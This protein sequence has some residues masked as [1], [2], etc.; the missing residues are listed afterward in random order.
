MVGPPKVVNLQVHI[1]FF[2]EHNRWTVFD[3][4]HNRTPDV[5]GRLPFD[6]A[7]LL[8]QISQFWW[9]QISHPGQLFF[10]ALQR[11]NLHLWLSIT[12][13]NTR[14]SPNL[15]LGRSANRALRRRPPEFRHAIPWPHVFS[16]QEVKPKRRGSPLVPP[17]LETLP[18]QAMPRK[19]GLAAAFCF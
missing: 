10:G 17:S 9:V 2:G 18:G 15:T 11:R 19:Q 8:N 1:A 6:G 12:S 5:E 13:S 7:E 4:K 3:G 14:R 16:T